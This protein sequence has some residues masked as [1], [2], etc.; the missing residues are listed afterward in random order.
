MWNPGSWY[1]IGQHRVGAV[2]VSQK[3]MGQLAIPIPVSVGVVPARKRSRE[4]RSGGPGPL[5]VGLLDPL[6]SGAVSPALV[7]LWKNVAGSDLPLPTPPVSGD[8]VLSWKNV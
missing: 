6:S 2:L 5:L 7:I 1:L 3:P 4:T 8:L